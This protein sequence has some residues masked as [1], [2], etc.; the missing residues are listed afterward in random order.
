M[1]E[2]ETCAIASPHTD[3]WVRY[4]IA[5]IGLKQWL[6]NGPKIVFSYKVVAP[7]AN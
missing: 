4:C 3:C 5:D 1:F 2:I 7:A 6:E